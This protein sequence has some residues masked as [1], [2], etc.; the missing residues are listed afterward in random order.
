MLLFLSHL[1]SFSLYAPAL[2]LQPANSF[3]FTAFYISWTC[4]I[5]FFIC[6]IFPSFFLL[7]SLCCCLFYF[8][9]LSL[10]SLC[11]RIFHIC[12]IFLFKLMSLSFL[13]PFSLVPAVTKTF[14]SF[15]FLYV[16]V[17]FS[18][19]CCLFHAILSVSLSLS[20]YFCCCVF[21]FILLYFFLYSSV[22][23]SL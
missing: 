9:L 17:S 19:D 13:L 10:I 2:S 8:S 12:C 16:A 20:L 11:C 6:R 1:T 15:L 21:S 18:S 23:H 3:S 22:S 7:Y 4:F 14:T 5:I